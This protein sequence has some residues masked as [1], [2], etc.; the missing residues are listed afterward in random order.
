MA[1]AKSM[2][3]RRGVGSITR[4]ETSSGVKWRWQI[5]IPVDAENPSAGTRLAGQA[6]YSSMQEADDALQDFRR[7]SESQKAAQVSGLPTIQDFAA[8]WLSGLRLE[9][10]TI[11]GYEKLIRNHINPY[12]GNLRLDQITATRIARLYREL[13]NSGRKDSKAYGQALSANTVNKVHVT[14]GALLDAAV[15][16][17]YISVNPAR[18]KRVV[19]APTGKQIRAQKRE[20]RTWT[21][22]QL[23]AFLIWDKESFKDELHALWHVIAHTGMRRSEALALKWNDIDTSN[24]RISIRRAADVTKRNVEKTTKT[25]RS[26]VVDIDGAT[27]EVLKAWKSIRGSLSLDL[28]RP[29]AYVFGNLAGE[30]RSPNEVGARWTYRVKKAREEL[31]ADNLPELTIHG[32]RHTHATLLMSI[33]EHPK[34]VQERLGH[35]DIST[36]M[37]IY[38]HVTPTMQ[39]DAVQRLSQLF[40]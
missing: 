16:D 23:Q 29:E 38:S 18:Q 15:A 32:L 4:Y 36:T 7:L 10:S 6:G 33:G 37:N 3:R 30:M 40:S 31:G 8:E 22:Q 17:G 11:Y 39:R 27:V 34:I 24:E 28:A 19:N 2:S 9:N 26:R 13:Q 25:G 14:L 12:L 21:A 1:R 35:T 20:M 5:R